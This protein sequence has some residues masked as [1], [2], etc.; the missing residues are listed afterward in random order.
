[1]VNRHDDEKHDQHDHEVDQGRKSMRKWDQHPRKI[2]FGDELGV[3]D[4]AGTAPLRRLR[5][6][7][8]SGQS[9]K[10]KQQ[11]GHSIAWQFSNT[12]KNDRENNCRNQRLQRD[13][14]HAERGLFVNYL[15]IALNQDPEQIAITPKLP[16]IERGPA[17]GRTNP[18]R[19]R[20]V[21]PR[22]GSGRSAWF[23]VGNSG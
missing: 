15:D 22:H 5:K 9:A 2:N 11:V 16:E 19:R 21:G 13:P 18:K 20:A 12:A 23:G 8:P 17:L 10:N 3:I 4:Q 14:G 6:I 7:V 1:M